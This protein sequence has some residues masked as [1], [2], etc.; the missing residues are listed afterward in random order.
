MRK[1]FLIPIL[2]LIV[3][4]TI[5]SQTRGTKIGYIDMEYILQNVPNY[6][7]ANVQ[8]EQ[9]A[10]KWKQEI[11]SKKIEIDKIKEAL[12]AEKALLTKGLI[13]ERELEIEFLE[14]EMLDFQQKRFGPYGLLM[15]HK[16]ILVK[17]IQD[18]VFTAVQ[19]IAE[20]KRYDF[21]FDK[22]SDLTMLF[23]AKRFD[24]SDQVL[25]VLNRAEKR[26][27]LT[28]KQIE[29]EDAKESKEDAVDE[30]PAL[31]ER[32]KAL[33]EKK[34]ARDQIIADRKL[35]Q[36]EKKQAAEEKRK[37]I[38]A[39]REAQKNG[40]V[41]ASTT[42]DS[43][44]TTIIDDKDA[45]KSAVEEIKQNQI[46]ARAKV[47]EDRKKVI[48]DRKRAVEERRIRTIEVRDSIKKSREEQIK[49]KQ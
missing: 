40:T 13:E 42:T 43:K 1:H 25:R 44:K 12:K 18:Q 4:N 24:L 34:N 22:S 48:E 29:A 7:E 45:A 3:V 23:S 14:N 5:Q 21:I 30:N 15:T 20:T 46:D 31:A 28:K 9:K 49:L 6:T 33:E 38:I 32:Q 41:S 17:P 27:E 39:E 26:E 37:E 36:E 2:A 8:L 19:D 47:L 11:E 16:S 10:Q 35:A